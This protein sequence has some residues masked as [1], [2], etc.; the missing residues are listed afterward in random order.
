MRPVE[1]GEYDAFRDLYAVAPEGVGA[2]ARELGGALCMRLDAIAEMAMF[3]RATGL[4]LDRPATEEALDEILGFLEGTRSYVSLAPEARP[5]Q[6]SGW[7]EARGLAPGYA[8]TKFS[9]RVTDPPAAQTTLRVEP[10]TRADEGFG[11]AATAGFEVPNLFRDWLDRLPGRDGWHCFVAFDGDEP[12]GAGALF[13][14]GTTG[15]LGVG[16][17]VPE[18]RGKGAQGAIIARRIAAARELGCD[19][20]VTETGEPIEGRPGPSYRNLLRAGFEPVYVRPA[21]ERPAAAS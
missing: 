10:V 19:V 2:D 18:H 14:T 21:Y 11:A 12:A 7:L 16:A 1:R 4:G 9:R 3:N 15:W 13:V 20:V 17:T 8:W 5:P 6:L